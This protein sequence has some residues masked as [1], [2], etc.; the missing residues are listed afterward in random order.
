MRAK[1]IRYDQWC[2]GVTN[3][4]AAP[5]EEEHQEA[6]SFAFFGGEGFA[7]TGSSD[8]SIGDIFTTGARGRPQAEAF[9]R[10]KILHFP[11]DRAE[12]WLPKAASGA[13]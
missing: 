12:F 2:E 8:A 5:T 1:V 11:W 9:L 7:H 10:E 6:C 4:D 3:S 13:C